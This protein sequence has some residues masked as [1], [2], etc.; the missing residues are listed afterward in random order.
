M[1]RQEL[2]KLQRIDLA[3]TQSLLQYLGTFSRET[4]RP[5]P[6]WPQLNGKLS[7]RW[8]MNNLA[9][10]IPDAWIV[11]PGNGNGHAYG[12]QKHTD[13]GQQFGLTWQDG[14]FAAG[15]RFTDPNY[16]GHWK[17]IHQLN[18]NSLPANPDFFQIIDYAMN[19][20]NGGV[21]DPNHVRNTSMSERH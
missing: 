19:Q 2:I 13:F 12:L 11:H 1:T 21:N 10:A 3:F 4:N 6:D 18:V 5:A 14:T 16:Y 9:L 20:A 17:Y 8:D 15:T 7:A